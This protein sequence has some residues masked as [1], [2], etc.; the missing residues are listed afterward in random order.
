MAVT[1]LIVTLIDWIDRKRCRKNVA[2]EN[3]SS[4]NSTGIASQQTFNLI[5]K[6]RRTTKERRRNLL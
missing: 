4:D 6:L 2:T 5:E 3:F 1:D